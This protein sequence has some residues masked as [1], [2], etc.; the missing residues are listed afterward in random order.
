ME[1]SEVIAVLTIYNEWRRGADIKQPD[2]KTIGK[3]ID[4][5]IKYLKDDIR[6]IKEDSIT[7]QN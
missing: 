1:K 3:A 2:P 7:C 6:P 4:F 5:A